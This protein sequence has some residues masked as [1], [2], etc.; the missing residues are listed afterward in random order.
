[1]TVMSRLL[2]YTHPEPNSGCWLWIGCLTKG[3]FRGGYGR[4]NVDGK[5]QYA[6]R[7]SYELLRGPIPREL[8]LDHLCCVKCCVNPDHLEP[9]THKVNTQRGSSK[10]KA[11]RGKQAA[12]IT[13]CPSGHPYSGDNLYIANG[14]RHCLTC[15]REATRRW[16]ERNKLVKG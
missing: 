13:H 5:V 15:K 8:E 1:M 3:R 2:K 9:V 6:H 10:V 7:V 4:L 16:R 14:C 12:A 11:T